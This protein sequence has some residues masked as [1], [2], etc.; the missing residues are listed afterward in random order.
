MAG[1]HKE[2]VI[3]AE[4]QLS[5]SFKEDLGNL[6]KYTKYNRLKNKRSI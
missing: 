4:K 5:Y 1:K 6:W 2:Q 3:K